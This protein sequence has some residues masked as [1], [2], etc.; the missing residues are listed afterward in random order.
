VRIGGSSHLNRF[1]LT[2]RKPLCESEGFFVYKLAEVSCS[3]GNLSGKTLT[4][5]LLLPDKFAMAEM[6]GE[7]G[8][9]IFKS[10][11]ICF[12]YK[13]KSVIFVHNQKPQTK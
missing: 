13:D 6:A 11:L 12:A 7:S 4:P 3:G 10:F 1:D 9:I 5:Q 2:T 8:E